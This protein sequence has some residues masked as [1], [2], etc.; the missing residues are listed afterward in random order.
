MIIVI[1]II[2]IVLIIWFMPSDKCWNCGSNQIYDWSWKKSV[3]ADC[4]EVQ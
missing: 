4:G 2:L 1:A 3:C